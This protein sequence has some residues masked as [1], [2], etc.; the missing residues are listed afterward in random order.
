MQFNLDKKFDN[1]TCKDASSA[2]EI[3]KSIQK[4]EDKYQSDLE[5]MYDNIQENLLKRV[6]RFVP[7]TGQRFDWTQPLGVYRWIKINK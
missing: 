2:K 5:D 7:L 1:I 3:I 6:R 4:A